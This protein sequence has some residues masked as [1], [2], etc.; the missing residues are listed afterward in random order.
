MSIYSKSVFDGNV[1]TTDANVDMH[2][3]CGNYD[4]SHSIGNAVIKTILEGYIAYGAS[5]ESIKSTKEAQQF[6][7]DFSKELVDNGDLS[8]ADLAEMNSWVAN[9]PQM[10][11]NTMTKPRDQRIFSRIIANYAED[12]VCDEIEEVKTLQSKLAKAKAKVLAKYGPAIGQ[13]VLQFIQRYGRTLDKAYIKQWQEF[14]GVSD[15]QNIIV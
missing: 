5:T 3:S 9:H 8:S 12:G 2:P 1:K 4:A 11:T 15:N 10:F 14:C 13:E 7:S 6:I